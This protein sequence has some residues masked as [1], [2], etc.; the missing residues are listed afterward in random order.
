M[1]NS[2][3]KARR[4]R[5]ATS[6]ISVRRE[7]ALRAGLFDES[8]ERRQDMEFLVRLA[9]VARCATTNERLWTKYEQAESISFTGDGFIA[10]T[11]IMRRSHPE[12]AAKRAYLPAD[13]AIY[14]WETIKRRRYARVGADLKQLARELGVMATLSLVVRGA[15]AWLIDPRLAILMGPSSR[16]RKPGRLGRPGPR[17]DAT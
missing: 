4:L 12:Y 3:V 8:V 10:A 9:K 15:W 6:G 17:D 2:T 11:L 1:F 5:K 13:V 14:L 16:G 7:I